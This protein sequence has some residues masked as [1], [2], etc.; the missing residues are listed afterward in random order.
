M[1]FDPSS[2]YPSRRAYVVK[3][4]SD[5]TRGALAGRLE[6]LITGMQREFRSGGELLDAIAADLKKNAEEPDG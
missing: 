3:M 5:A 2:R 4:R 6:N 1:P